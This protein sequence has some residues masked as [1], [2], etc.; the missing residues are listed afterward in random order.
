MTIDDLH[1]AMVRC[2]P[3]DDRALAEAAKSALARAPVERDDLDVAAHLQGVLGNVYP[4]VEVVPMDP[5]AS[6]WGERAWYVYRDGR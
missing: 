5:L 4:R 6:E 2:I 3:S 1:R